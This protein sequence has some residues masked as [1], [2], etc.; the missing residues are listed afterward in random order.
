MSFVIQTNMALNLF[1]TDELSFASL[2]VLF[3]WLCQAVLW[4]FTVS[5]GVLSSVVLYAAEFVFLLCSICVN[6]GRAVLVGAYSSVLP[7]VVEVGERLV[8]NVPFVWDYAKLLVLNSFHLAY[9]VCVSVLEW[10]SSLAMYAF[11]FSKWFIV[12]VCTDAASYMWNGM[13]TTLERTSSVTMVVAS[14]TVA[15]VVR[16][17]TLAVQGFWVTY[18][19]VVVGAESAFPAVRSLLSYGVLAGAYVFHLIY[20]ACVALVHYGSVFAVQVYQTVAFSVVYIWSEAVPASAYIWSIVVAGFEWV[21]SLSWTVVSRIPAGVQVVFSVVAEG[22][23]SAWSVVVKVVHRSYPVIAEVLVAGLRWVEDIRFAVHMR[24]IAD[25]LWD[26]VCTIGSLLVMVAAQ[27][28]AV[29]VLMLT[30]LYSAL[31]M[32]FNMS[33]WTASFLVYNVVT[34]LCCIFVITVIVVVCRKILQCTGVTGRGVV[35]V[36]FR[37]LN[38]LFTSLRAQ[39]QARRQLQQEQQVR[40]RG[41]QPPVQGNR[42]SEDRQDRAT[43][44]QQDLLRGVLRS[45]PKTDNDDHLCVICCV[46]EKA[47]MLRPCNHVCLCTECGNNSIRQ[48]N[49]NCPICRGQFTKTERVYI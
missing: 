37:L 25:G 47:I 16:M 48:L 49:G 13:V 18:N 34:V 42:A 33:R 38:Q 35:L 29:F 46:N 31:F 23:L 40:E 2:T 8:R 21:Y 28:W 11:S 12:C 1:L 6:S 45:A 22:A 43:R 36:A 14:Y 32:V 19:G 7:G 20:S 15:G 44:Q 9:N 30:F 17:Y 26:A 39:M 41:I 5:F 3:N 27:V 10:A 4:I 24:W